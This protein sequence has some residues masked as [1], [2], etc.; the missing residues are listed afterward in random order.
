MNESKITIHHMQFCNRLLKDKYTILSDITEI[1]NISFTKKNKI[2]I[3]GYLSIYK[4]YRKQ[5]YGYKIIEY[6]LSHYNINCIVGQS[7]KESRTFW[8]KCIKKFNGQRRNI[9][10]LDN[11]SSSFVIP[12]YK[13]SDQE[14]CKILEIGYEIESSFSLIGDRI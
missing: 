5:G 10:T 14:L 4:K 9:T 3:I 7:L 2:L 13:I 8:N 1:G 12:R 11:C 6:L